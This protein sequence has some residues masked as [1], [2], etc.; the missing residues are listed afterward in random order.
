MSTVTSREKR[1][2][3]MLANVFIA[4]IF[5]SILA[6]CIDGFVLHPIPSQG[7]EGDFD[8]SKT[9]TAYADATVLDHFH[10][11]QVGEILLVEKGEEIHLLYFENHFLTGRR[12]LV[13]DI[14]IDG[15]T[16][17]QLSV[18]LSH[19]RWSLTVED[20]A[21]HDLTFAGYSVDREGTMYI[22]IGVVFT[23]LESVVFWLIIRK[24]YPD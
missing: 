12:V 17:Q 13:D 15:N 11:V 1:R 24:V 8:L 2:K 9:D 14:V 18:G 6:F 20:G 4:L 21:I 10:D 3:A 5:F 22:L 23:V 19:E 16:S 7:N